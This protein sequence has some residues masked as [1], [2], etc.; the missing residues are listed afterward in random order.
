[1]RIWR[2]NTGKAPSWDGLRVITFGVKGGAD[3]SGLLRGGRRLE[4]E[5]KKPGGR[6]SEEQKAFQRMIEGLG[7]LYILAFSVDD[8]REALE[9]NGFPV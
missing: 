1:M 4:I 7:G 9:A 8:V 2:Q 3:I 6:Q 5:V